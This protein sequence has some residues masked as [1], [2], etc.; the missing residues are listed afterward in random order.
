MY[1]RNHC[2]P[3]MS[4]GWGST[5]V[6]PGETVT[7]TLSIDQKVAI[8]GAAFEITYNS[9]AY[10]YE[11]AVSETYEDVDNFMSTDKG[12]ETINGD[13]TAVTNRYPL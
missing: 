12:K 8:G 10:T 4:P 9:D 3:Y 1:Y 11:G 5:S 6:A 7:L 13:G 2:F